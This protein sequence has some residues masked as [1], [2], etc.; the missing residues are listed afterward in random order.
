MQWKGIVFVLGMAVVLHLFGRTGPESASANPKQASWFSLSGYVDQLGNTL[1]DR[2]DVIAQRGVTVKV[3]PAT[4]SKLAT[5]Q[6]YSVDIDI[7]RDKI[8][9][10]KK[11]EPDFLIEVQAC[12][13][14]SNTCQ[15]FWLKRS[16]WEAYPW[17]N[18]Y[19]YKT[20]RTKNVV[21]SVV[22]PPVT[23][24]CNCNCD[25]C[26]CGTGVPCPCTCVDCIANQRY[27]Q[28]DGS[29]YEPSPVFSYAAYE[30][31]YGS[32]GGDGRWFPGKLVGRFLV[33]A[34]RARPKLLPCRRC[35]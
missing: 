22:T 4:S 32:L 8:P 10:P 29:F 20:I 3:N 9:S 13:K 16:R 23:Q 25:Q 24:T 6:P 15:R 31:S 2:A 34:E 17:S 27:Q 7:D 12:H 1:M 11:T 33:K 28:S 35:R 14:F 21:Q 26:T 18:D 19:I 5:Q 30:G